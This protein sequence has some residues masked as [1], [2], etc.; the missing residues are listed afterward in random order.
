MDR[1][2]TCLV[3][4]ERSAG[5]GY[6][7]A[8]P[9][10]RGGTAEVADVLAVAAEVQRAAAIDHEGLVDRQSVVAG[11]QRQGALVDGGLPG[12]AVSDGKNQRAGACL[13]EACRAAGGTDN[14]GDGRRIGVDRNGAHGSVEINHIRQRQHA[15][16]RGLIEHQSCRSEGRTVPLDFGRG[17]VIDR[18]LAGGAVGAETA[19]AAG[20]L[21]LIVARAQAALEIAIG[22]LHHATI[23]AERVGAARH[24]STARQGVGAGQSQY[25]S[26][27]RGC[28]G[29]GVAAGEGELA[30]AD[31]RQVEIARNIAAND[32]VSRSGVD[33]PIGS[34]RDRQVDSLRVRRLVQDDVAEPVAGQGDAVAVKCE[35][36]GSA[37]ELEAG[38]RPADDII[39]ERGAAGAGC[40]EGQDVAGFRGYPAPVGRIAPI[41]VSAAAIPIGALLDGQGDEAP[42]G[43]EGV[44]LTGGF[45]LHGQVGGAAGNAAGV[46]DEVIG[47]QRGERGGAGAVVEADD[48]AIDRQA[49]TVGDDLIETAV[50]VDV[51]CQEAAALE[52][53]AA[54]ADG[55]DGG[56]SAGADLAAASHAHRAGDGAG[57]GDQLAAADRQAVALG[58][59]AAGQGER[60][61]GQVGAGDILAGVHDQFAADVESGA[62]GN[63]E[64]GE[65]RR[66]VGLGD[67]ERRGPIQRQRAASGIKGRHRG[68]VDRQGLAGRRHRTAGDRQSSAGRRSAVDGHQVPVHGY[69]IEGCRNKSRVP[70]AYGIPVGTGGADQ[71]FTG[72]AGNADIVHAKP[73]PTTIVRVNQVQG[74]ASPHVRSQFG[75]GERNR[76][77]TVACVGPGF[78]EHENTGRDVAQG[79]ALPAASIYRGI[80]YR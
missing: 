12:V 45:V 5:A 33:R 2:V 26:V 62:G 56:V 15:V 1:W 79:H 50:A 9:F 47:S 55:A 76:H 37:L 16:G 44:P 51:E 80:R 70:G 61:R 52:R 36:R 29:V 39:I 49:A 40:C 38:E 68:I 65:T 34:Q 18:D 30:V 17:V 64:A 20:D 14:A 48:P 75:C 69:C 3:D 54:G 4:R 74:E 66:G 28:T 71:R 73:A 8:G 32:D 41:R 46:T 58:Q 57:A 23:D 24:S 53:Q 10:V 77:H 25:A 11:G 43:A 59:R 22:Q 60:G 72:D 27:H 31:L 67:V 78:G 21:K 19:G 7:P 35:G 6:D 13:D 63:R 42:G